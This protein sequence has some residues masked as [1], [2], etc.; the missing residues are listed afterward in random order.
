MI[1]W[2]LFGGVMVYIGG[3]TLDRNGLTGVT[4]P[5]KDTMNNLISLKEFNAS[6]SIQ[7]ICYKR[8]KVM[9]IRTTVNKSITFRQLNPEIVKTIWQLNIHKRKKRGR[10]G[11][12]TVVRNAPSF[13][14]VNFLTLDKLLL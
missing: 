10:R 3:E 1:F 2:I 8:I 4:I 11:G 7:H 14:Y 6:N 13:R 12:V 9:D 5:Y